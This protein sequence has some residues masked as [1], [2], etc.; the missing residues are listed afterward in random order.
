MMPNVNIHTHTHL[1][2]FFFNGIALLNVS[3]VLVPSVFLLWNSISV[4]LHT[5]TKCKQIFVDLNQWHLWNFVTAKYENCF[6]NGF[7]TENMC[8]SSMNVSIL[9]VSNCYFIC[10]SIKKKLKRRKNWVIVLESWVSCFE[11]RC[12][13]PFISPN[14]FI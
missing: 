7:Q 13:E 4:T 1:A 9:F 12:C 6:S 5:H 3:L 8:D 14:N 2:F 11:Y 10:Q